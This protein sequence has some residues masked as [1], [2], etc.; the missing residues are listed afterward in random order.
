MSNIVKNINCTE[1]WNVRENN[2]DIKWDG[3]Q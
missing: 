2:K 3:M 1:Y